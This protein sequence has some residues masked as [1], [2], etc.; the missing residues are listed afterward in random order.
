MS[1]KKRKLHITDRHLRRKAA[2]DA[3]DFLESIINAATDIENTSVVNCSSRNESS[4]PI[5][6][7]TNRNCEISDTVDYNSFNFNAEISTEE[8]TIY[9]NTSGNNKF[10]V[11]CGNESAD[12]KDILN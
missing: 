3:E 1:E 6:D 10:N 9:I 4:S 12:A 8:N 11:V 7:L 5:N 2:K